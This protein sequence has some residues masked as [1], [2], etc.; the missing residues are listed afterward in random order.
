MSEASQATDARDPYEALGIFADTWTCIGEGTKKDAQ[1]YLW[2][3]ARSGVPALVADGPNGMFHVAVQGGLKGNP[4]A[5]I[6]QLRG[7]PYEI[8]TCSGTGQ[9]PQEGR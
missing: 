5:W 9:H 3:L 6:I 8:K 4:A 1:F 7:E 2:N